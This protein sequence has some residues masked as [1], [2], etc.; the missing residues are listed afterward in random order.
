MNCA[1]AENQYSQKQKYLMK[2]SNSPLA[3]QS[4]NMSS[5]LFLAV[6]LWHLQFYS[7]GDKKKIRLQ[8]HTQPECVCSKGKQKPMQINKTV[9]F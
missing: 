4:W 1:P 6:G 3:P 5:F 7:K 9:D 8:E 2:S